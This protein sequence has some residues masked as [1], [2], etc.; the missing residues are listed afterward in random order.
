M[1]KSATSVADFTRLFNSRLDALARANGLLA[2]LGERER[3]TFD[4]LL[5]TELSAHG[6]RDENDPRCALE[7]PR[8]IR[9]RSTTVQTLALGI[10]ELATNA[11]KYGALSSDSGRLEVRWRVVEAGA[12]RRLEVA[13]RETGVSIE[14]EA[15]QPKQDAFGREL[16]ERAI[17]YQLKATTSYELTPT[18]VHC[19]ISLPF[20]EEERK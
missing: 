10:H 5:R 17:P 13:W 4:E 19:T 11:V 2:R 12:E 9:L 7:G 3:I 14:E 20:A 6:V 18:G 16:I 1:A 15:R 8:G